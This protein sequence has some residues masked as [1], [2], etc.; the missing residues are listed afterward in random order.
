[1]NKARGES[2][3]F[4]S[5]L[6]DYRQAKDVTKRRLYLEAMGTLLNNVDEIYVID[7]DQKGVLPLL[8]LQ[9]ARGKQNE[10]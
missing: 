8:D 2:D 9:K 4:L 10:K 6:R 7:A 3:R 5:V 1:M